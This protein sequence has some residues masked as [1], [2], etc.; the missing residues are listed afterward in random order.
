M[1]H[2]IKECGMKAFR[3]EK[4]N[5]YYLIKKYCIQYIKN[6]GVKKGLFRNNI[7]IN[8]YIDEQES[9]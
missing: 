3:M 1:D 9:K 7:L 4:E 8:L 6:E 5:W 2:F